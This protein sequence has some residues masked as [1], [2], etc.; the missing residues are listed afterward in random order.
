MNQQ[1]LIS[2]QLHIKHGIIILLPRILP[3]GGKTQK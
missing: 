1:L 2:K 3:V